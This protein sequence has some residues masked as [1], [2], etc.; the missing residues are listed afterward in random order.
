MIDALS[1]AS[2]FRRSAGW[3]Y[4][5]IQATE[6][7]YE[8]GPGT[9]ILFGKTRLKFPDY[10]DSPYFL[11]FFPQYGVTSFVLSIYSG[12]PA[13]DPVTHQ[14]QQMGSNYFFLNST[15]RFIETYQSSPNGSYQFVMFNNVAAGFLSNGFVWAS[16]R[17]GTKFK[18]EDGVFNNVPV[19]DAEYDAER[20]LPT[21]RAL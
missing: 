3:I 1:F 8:R 9:R 7:D 14:P 19:T 20:S 2:A 10:A 16:L 6:L 17:D 12:S 5:I 15:G 4:P 13:I 21:A 18:V 11:E